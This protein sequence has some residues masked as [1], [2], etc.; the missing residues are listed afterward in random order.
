MGAD[1]TPLAERLRRPLGLPS[2][3]ARRFTEMRQDAGSLDLLD[4]VP[5][6]G[7]VRPAA[8]T[9]TGTVMIGWAGRTV[10]R[11]QAAAS[12]RGFES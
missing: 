12:A 9:A 6:A 10:I 4:R 11:L 2:P 1:H 3:V 7:F 8:A 5:T